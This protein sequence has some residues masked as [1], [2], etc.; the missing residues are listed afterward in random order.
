VSEFEEILV[1]RAQS[2]AND[3]NFWQ[4][5]REKHDKRLS[6]ERHKPLASHRAEE[7]K[8]MRENFYGPDPAYHIARQK[9]VYK[10]RPPGMPEMPARTELRTCG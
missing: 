2:L 9:F 5:L 6:D 4:L 7:L 1:S 10:G 3:P 8:R